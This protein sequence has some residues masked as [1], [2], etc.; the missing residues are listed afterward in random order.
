MIA[1]QTTPARIRYAA[2]KAANPIG[3]FS[4]RRDEGQKTGS[5]ESIPKLI[6][7]S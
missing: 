2:R 1:R 6:D 5:K 7:R 3:V 4:R